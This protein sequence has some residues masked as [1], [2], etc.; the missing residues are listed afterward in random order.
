[1][2]IQAKLQSGRSGLVGSLFSSFP[3]QLVKSRHQCSPFFPYFGGRD[4]R[5][6]LF[7]AESL[8]AIPKKPI[9]P[10]PYRAS[11]ATTEA[12]TVIRQAWPSWVR[13]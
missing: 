1:M 12:P 2:T 5:Q 3:D 6:P 13:V 8:W 4:R 10:A 9:F 11:T 7:F